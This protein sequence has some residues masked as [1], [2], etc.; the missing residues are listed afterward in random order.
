MTFVVP[1]GL[2]RDAWMGTQCRIF[3]TESIATLGSRLKPR[4]RR[5]RQDA[6]TGR[7]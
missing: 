1:A 6:A 4:E 7:E 3:S 2:P 5:G